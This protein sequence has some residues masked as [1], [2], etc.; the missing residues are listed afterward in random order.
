MPWRPWKSSKW[1]I[2]SQDHVI[3]N[4]AILPQFFS[5][6]SCKVS[7]SDSRGTIFLHIPG[8]FP[9]K[10][11]ALK[12]K[13]SDF[14]LVNLFM[15]FMVRYKILHSCRC[16]LIYNSHSMT[17][18]IHNHLIQKLFEPGGQQMWLFQCFDSKVK[19]F[20]LKHREI[21]CSLTEDNFQLIKL[22]S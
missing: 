16:N 5:R 13:L 7:L 15:V 4:L 22:D 21:V 20:L 3:T 14:N 11:L 2:C 9:Q 8:K 1:K 6:Q 17:S 19:Q 18:K 10:Y 12:E